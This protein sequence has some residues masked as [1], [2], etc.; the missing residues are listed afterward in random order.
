MKGSDFKRMM[1]KWGFFFGVCN[2]LLSAFILG[3]GNLEYLS[4]FHTFTTLFQC[5]VRWYRFSQQKWEFYMYD[6]CYFA[7]LTIIVFVQFYRK[8]EIFFIIS[9]CISHGPLLWAVVLYSN[10]LVFHSHTKLF[11]FD[12][13][14]ANFV[15]TF[16]SQYCNV[17]FEMA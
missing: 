1:D 15:Y 7:N 12:I 6:F 4:F 5:T 10:S 16:I 3:T 11:Y 17:F 2:L 8:S 14:I 13:Q 9:Y